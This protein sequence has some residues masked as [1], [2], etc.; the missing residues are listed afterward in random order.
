MTVVQGNLALASDYNT[1]KDEVNKWFGDSNPSMTFGDGDQSYGWGG[2]NAAAVVQGDEMLASEMN[3]LVD[4][5]NIGVGICSSVSGT[6]SQSVSGNAITASEFN[7][8]ETKS[9][10][11]DTNR[12]GID[13]AELSLAAGGNSVRSTTWSAAIDC[14][15]RYTFSNFAGARYFF[16][17]GGAF[18]ISATIASYSTGTG[19]DGAGFNEIFTTMGTILMDYTQTTQSGSGGTPTSI[20]YFDLT[21]SY[22][23]IFSQTGSGAYT[24]A[25]MVIEAR[26]SATGDYV[27]IRITLTPGAG[28]SVDGTTTI[29]TQQRKL[30]NQ[31]SGAA[32]LTITA[33]SYSLIDGL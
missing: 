21:A 27:E 23:T 2:S 32:S 29:T 17:S 9:D 24:D 20:G 8:I 26:R 22:Q 5:C 31:S 19:W 6:L 4:R 10:S 18:N 12:L 16:N 33:P 15:F 1:L 7:D 14:T 13:A 25:T 11:L 3:A 30:D 28:R